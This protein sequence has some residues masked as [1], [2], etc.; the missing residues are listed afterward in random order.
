MEKKEEMSS[1]N[2]LTYEQLTDRNPH[3][4]DIDWMEKM[5]IS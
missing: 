2:G 1:V 3:D 5:H 4:V